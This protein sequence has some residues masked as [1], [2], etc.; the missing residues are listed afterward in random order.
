MKI[1]R[2]AS[3]SRL[4]LLVA[5]AVVALSST[6]AGS[7]DAPPKEAPP[8]DSPTK[9]VPTSYAPVVVKEDFQATKSRMAGDKPKVMKRQLD[10]LTQRYD[11]TDRP[12][13]GVTMARGK[14][15]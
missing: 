5:F 7:A 3:R 8:K 14:P 13:Q 1:A 15:V 10:L 9:G 12:A 6:L 11:L 4:D 2:T